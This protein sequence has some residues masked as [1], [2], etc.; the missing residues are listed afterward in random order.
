[1]DHL[2]THRAIASFAKTGELHTDL[3]LCLLLTRKVKK[4]QR[5]LAAAVADSYEQITASTINNFRKQHFTRDETTAT[6]LERTQ[7]DELRTVFVSERQQ[8]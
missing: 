2:N 5:E 1:M 7:F 4:A 3:K 8:E 6:R